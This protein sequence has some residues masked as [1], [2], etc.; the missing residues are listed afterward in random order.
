M[1]CISG[2]VTEV[3]GGPRPRGPRR[4]QYWKCSVTLVFASL[5]SIQDLPYIRS[6]PAPFQPHR[7][8]SASSWPRAIWRLPLHTNQNRADSNVGLCHGVCFQRSWGIK[9]SLPLNLLYPG[10]SSVCCR[11]PPNGNVCPQHCVRKSTAFGQRKACAI[12]ISGWMS[13]SP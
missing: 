5:L 7:R 3:R 11:D 10:N 9:L 1:T 2:P 12:S 4:Q 13:S 6:T 8:V